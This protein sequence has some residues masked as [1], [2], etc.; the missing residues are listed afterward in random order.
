MLTYL[1]PSSGPLG[2]PDTTNFDGHAF[3]IDVSGY[4]RGIGRREEANIAGG[5]ICWVCKDKDLVNEVRQMRY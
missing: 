1:R 4:A 5:V 3:G 2:H